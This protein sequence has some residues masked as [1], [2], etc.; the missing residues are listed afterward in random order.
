MRD[1]LKGF[2]EPTFAQACNKHRILQEDNDGAHGTKT[3]NNPNAIAIWKQEHCIN[4]LKW[5]PQSPDLSPI[6]NVWRF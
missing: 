2:I 5:P 1:C 6:E 4:C 3:I